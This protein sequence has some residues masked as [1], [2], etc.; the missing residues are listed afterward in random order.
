MKPEKKDP[1]GK[2]N[3]TVQYAMGFNECY[4]QLEAWVVEEL[5]SIPKFNDVS[6]KYIDALIREIKG[7][8]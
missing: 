3:C 5:E 4:D 8:K 7:E 2:D 1:T 6:T